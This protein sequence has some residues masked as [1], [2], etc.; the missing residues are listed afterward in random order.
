M[1]KERKVEVHG[2]CWVGI[3]IY[4]RAK[5]YIKS[6]SFVETRVPTEK[7]LQAKLRVDFF[8]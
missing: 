2:I 6:S 5:I 4:I 1:E 7:A 3:T 8:K